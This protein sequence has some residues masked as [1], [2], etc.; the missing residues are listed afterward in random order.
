MKE[1]TFLKNEW[2][3][4]FNLYAYTSTKF[5]RIAGCFVVGFEMIKIPNRGLIQP[6][7]MVYPLWRDDI[8]LCMKHPYV[9]YGL[10][11]KNNLQVQ[12]PIQEILQTKDEI[13]KEFEEYIGFDIKKD[14]LGTDMYVLI[15]KCF[16][17]QINDPWRLMEVNESNIILSTYMNDRKMFDK[18]VQSLDEAFIY[19]RPHLNLIERFYGKY[20]GWK[21]DLLSSFCD[22]DAI[23]TR[24]ENNIANC[25]VN[26]KC[27]LLPM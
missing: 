14:I 4:H 26:S 6:H 5:Y 11:D 13:F 10:L 8:K 22:R 12:L 20:E 1:E 3:R 24:I 18:A 16:S 15:N 9:M 17:H 7:L 27:E 25:K 19:I 2:C 23:L 21:E